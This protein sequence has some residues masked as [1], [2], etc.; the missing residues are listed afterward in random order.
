MTAVLIRGGGDLGSGIALRLHRCGLKVIIAEISNPLVLRRKVAFASAVFNKTST[1]EGVTA[2]LISSPEDIS[3]ML[4][5]NTIPVIVDPELEI[6]RI[7]TFVIL[8]DARMQKRVH[9][10][11]LNSRPLILGL[12][13]GFTA[14]QNCHAAIE[15][16]RGHYLGRVIWEGSPEKDTGKAGNIGGYEAERVLRAPVEGI[17]SNG[18]MIGSLVKMGDTVALVDDTPVLAPLSGC[19]RGLMHDG[20]RVTQGLKIGD[21]DPRNDPELINTVSEKGLAIAGGVLEAIL[22]SNRFHLW[23]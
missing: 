16:N 15:T 17:I 18:L 8:V 14:T 13:P 1:V 10:Y 12:G 6:V 5:T 7:D 2:E 21:I 4:A 11:Q 9:Q 23:T 20:I 3:V 22:A 19:L